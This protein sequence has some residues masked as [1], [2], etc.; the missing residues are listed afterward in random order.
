MLLVDTDIMIDIL[1]GYFPAKAWLT[2]LGK[3]PILLPGFVVMELHQGCRN[4]TEQHTLMKTLTPYRHVWPSEETC[5]QAL[6]VFEQFHLSHGLGMLDALIGQTA[7][8]L[9][10]PVHTFNRKHYE[11]IPGIRTIQPY[12]KI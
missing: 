6:S 10:L 12:K 2:S 8:S 5:E 7:I 1:R 9:G 3:Q 4:T 11:M